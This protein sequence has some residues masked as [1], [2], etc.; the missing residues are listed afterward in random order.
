MRAALPREVRS[1]LPTSAPAWLTPSRVC[2]AVLT[3]ASTMSTA[4]LTSWVDAEGFTRAALVALGGLS[5][6]VAARYACAPTAAA[7][8]AVLRA[9]FAGALHAVA[10][11]L[12]AFGFAIWEKRASDIDLSEIVGV[13]FMSALLGAPFGAMVGLCYSVLPASLAKTRLRPTHADVER[14]LIVASAWLIPLAIVHGAASAF[15]LRPRYYYSGIYVPPL[16][17]Q[18]QVHLLWVLPVLTSV[19]AFAW[20]LSREIH[21]SRFLAKIRRGEDP[22]FR[23]LTRTRGWERAG[24]VPYLPN[25]DVAL[26][27]S[28]LV[29]VGDAPREVGYRE[30]A[31]RDAEDKVVALLP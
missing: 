13:I 3:F 20:F 19:I 27:T 25:T 15:V 31:E 8:R 11:C 18:V 5:S 29:R 12:V 6:F 30:R 16:T 24:I 22:R 21:A 26:C 4:L 2:V 28:V 7:G 1:L 23:I 17:L 14:T 9:M 10:M